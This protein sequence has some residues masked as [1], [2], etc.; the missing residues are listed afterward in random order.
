V[1][2]IGFVIPGFDF[3]Y[4]WSDIPIY[5]VMASDLFVLFGYF[6]IVRMLKENRF[7][8]TIIETSEEQ[9][10]IGTSPYRIVRHPMYAGVIIMMLLTPIALGSYWALIPFLIGTLF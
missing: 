2:L 1:F 10:V 5:V 8:S 9:K 7:A 6:F 4:S 3:R